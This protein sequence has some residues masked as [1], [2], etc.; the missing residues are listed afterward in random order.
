MISIKVLDLDIGSENLGQHPISILVL[1]KEAFSIEKYI[2]PS[3]TV[4][5]VCTTLR[6][7]LA[8]SGVTEITF[9]KHVSL[10]VALSANYVWVTL[11]ASS[12][13]PSPTMWG[14]DD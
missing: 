11:W 6:D 8:V 4:R 12:V 10:G 5:I 2:A 3:D 9:D 7:T 14:E 13:C 1:K